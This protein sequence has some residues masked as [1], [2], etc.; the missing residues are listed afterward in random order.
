MNDLKYKLKSCSHI[1]FY[2]RWGHTSVD[3]RWHFLL[4]AFTLTIKAID[5]LLFRE[6]LGKQAEDDSGLSHPM[7]VSGQ[8]NIGNNNRIVERLVTKMGNA[9]VCA[10]LVKP[11]HSHLVSSNNRDSFYPKNSYVTWAI[12][13][14]SEFRSL[15]IVM[16]G[17]YTRGKLICVTVFRMPAT[18]D[19]KLRLFKKN[20]N[21][22]I[23]RISFRHD[24][25]GVEV[26][27]LVQSPFEPMLVHSTTSQFKSNITDRS[28]NGFDIWQ[29][30]E[31]GNEPRLSWKFLW[32]C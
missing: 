11:Q 14:S 26:F 17:Q 2:E 28:L 22:F 32:L 4:T 8:F 19:V 3:R 31:S 10:W 13:S 5:G 16:N 7:H 12:L 30:T 29:K 6:L 1:P 27:R 20:I 15:N 18:L 9:N 24:D 25:H 23:L 21:L